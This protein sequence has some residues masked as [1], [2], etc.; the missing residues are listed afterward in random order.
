MGMS[1]YFISN[2]LQLKPGNVRVRTSGDVTE[3]VLKDTRDVHA[4]KNIHNPPIKA[5]F[6]SVDWRHPAELQS[7]PRGHVCKVT[8]CLMATLSAGVRRNIRRNCFF[9]LFFSSSRLQDQSSR[10]R[11]MYFDSKLFDRRL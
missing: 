4:L 3:M 5:N 11:M 10:I 1:D 6:L 9:F 2:T 8:E 7:P